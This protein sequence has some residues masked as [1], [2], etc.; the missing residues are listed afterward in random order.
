M[1]IYSSFYKVV[2]FIPKEG[3]DEWRSNRCEIWYVPGCE[4][5]QGWLDVDI[6]D[7]HTVH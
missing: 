3:T 4:E 6:T 1:Y 7:W 2:I 5:D